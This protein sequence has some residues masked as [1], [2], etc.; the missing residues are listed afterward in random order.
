MYY[1]YELTGLLH[2]CHIMA[3]EP[4]IILYYYRYC[5][6]NCICRTIYPCPPSSSFSS[7]SKTTAVLEEET[8]TRKRWWSKWR[9]NWVRCHLP[10]GWNHA[11]ECCTCISLQ[12]LKGYSNPA[13]GH[14]TFISQW[15]LTKC[16]YNYTSNKNLNVGMAVTNKVRKQVWKYLSLHHA[17]SHI[18]IP[19]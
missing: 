2:G 13:G 18:T 19:T 9:W 14:L 15:N 16:R 17:P 7:S 11:G 1:S 6:C 8:R 3:G 10:A 12:K 4:L 5:V